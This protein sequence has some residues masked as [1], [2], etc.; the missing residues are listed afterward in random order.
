MFYFTEDL[1]NSILKRSLVPISTKTF[2]TAD[3]ERFANEEMETFLINDIMTVRNDFF[4]RSKVITI[5]A[6]LNH[7]QIPER[8]IGNSLK[9]V[10]FTDLGGSQRKLTLIDFE[11][12][13]DQP[14]T[15]TYPVGFFFQDGQMVLVPTPQSACGTLTVWFYSRPSTLTDTSN[16]AKI[17]GVS[18]LSGTTT[19]TVDT[20]LT[21]S[22]A[23]GKTLDL[24]RA[25]SPFYNSAQDVLITAITGT[26]IAFAT[27]DV[28]NE[29]GTVLGATGDYICPPQKSNIPMIPQ[30][31]HPIL[32]A[33]VV[34]RILHSLGDLQKLQAL[35]AELVD[36]R[37][38][39]F[40]LISNRDE[41]SNPAIVSKRGIFS[42]LNWAGPRGGLPR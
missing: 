5:Q 24:L 18:S 4:L 8:A 21:G 6:L 23:V 26:T 3:L 17:T 20:D 40:A 28:S 33:L 37:R 11:E 39:A 9:D 22:F 7:Y 27:T 35:T 32:S 16:C 29:A 41:R 10:W 2:S 13:T 25:T 1:I 30:E 34:K 38:N 12:V 42:Y 19:F 14:S 36:M 31:F 15:A